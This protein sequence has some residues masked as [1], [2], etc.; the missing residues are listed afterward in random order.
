MSTVAKQNGTEKKEPNKKATPSPKETVMKK[1][2]EEA[3]GK[4]SVATLEERIENFEKL[5]G[6]A[7]QRERLLSTLND[8][9]KFKYNNGDSCVFLLRD[10]EGKEF[11]T[12][13]NNLILIVTNV[14]QDTLTVRKKEIENQILKFNL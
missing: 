10:E 8:L 2:A 11:K 6:L 14:L 3:I 13:N 5:K 4:N 7:A 12:T 1:L 9:T